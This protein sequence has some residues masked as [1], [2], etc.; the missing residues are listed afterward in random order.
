MELID[1][2]NPQGCEMCTNYG[3][4]VSSAEMSANTEYADTRERQTMHI[5]EDVYWR[6]QADKFN[7]QLSEVEEEIHQLQRK[8]DKP[9]QQLEDTSTMT[10]DTWA[11]T[12]VTN[13]HSSPAMDPIEMLCQQA[14]RPWCLNLGLLHHMHRHWR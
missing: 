9:E 8:I 4:H 14:G 13:T 6:R 3:T 1:H 7:H 10:E 12:C 2:P 11:N 5:Q